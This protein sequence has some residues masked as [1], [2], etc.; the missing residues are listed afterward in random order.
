MDVMCNIALNHTTSSLLAA[1][2]PTC[3]EF[4]HG[5]GGSGALQPGCEHP[6]RDPSPRSLSPREPQATLKHAVGGMSVV[7]LFPGTCR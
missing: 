1:L 7:D 5:A 3:P 2:Q 6:Q 4:L